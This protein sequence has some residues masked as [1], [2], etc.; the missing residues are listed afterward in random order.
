MMQLAAG[1]LGAGSTAM[2]MGDGLRSTA[3]GTIT[4]EELQAHSSAGSCWVAIG[5]SV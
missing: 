2:A 4:A 5:G 1:A 3:A